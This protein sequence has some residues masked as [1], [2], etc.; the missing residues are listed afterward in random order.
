MIEPGGGRFSYTYDANGRITR[1]INPQSLP[2]TWAYDN[3]GKVLAKYLANG[4]RAS[5]TWDAADRLTHLANMPPIGTSTSTF[6][7]AYD[8]ADNRTRVAE[9][10][11]NRVTWTYDASYQ[12]L[13]ER[14][15]GGSGYAITYSYDA[16]GNRLTM[17]QSGV[18]TTFTYDPANQLKTFKDNTGT[19]TLSWDNN[20]NQAGQIA[21]SGGR[22]TFTWDFENRSTQALLPLGLPNTMTYDADGRRVKKVD[23]S[24]TAKAVWD[25][26]NIL[27]ETDQSNVTQ[28]EYSLQP[29]DYGNLV[30]QYRSG[31]TQFFLFDALGSSDRLV[32]SAANVT[33][34]F[35]YRAFGQLQ[36]RTGPTVTPF[37]FVGQHQYYF[38]SDLGRHFIRARFYDPAVGRWLSKDPLGPVEDHNLYRYVNNRPA[39]AIDPSGLGKCPLTNAD[40]ARLDQLISDLGSPIFR[41][42]Q[43]AFA[44][45][46]IF[47]N[48]HLA[49]LGQI[50]LILENSS[51][52]TGDAEIRRLITRLLD[53]VRGRV[54]TYVDQ[55]VGPKPAEIV[56]GVGGLLVLLCQPSLGKRIRKQLDSERNHIER[57]ID[58]LDNRLSRRLWRDRAQMVRWLDQ[59][60]ALNARL[61]AIEDLLSLSFLVCP[62]I[63]FILG[64]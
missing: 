15:S 62:C 32:D 8:K 35:V 6:D 44:A 41:K 48:D 59:L 24:G 34:T 28:A 42:R 33:D 4:F 50:I 53:V 21:P 55:M 36:K 14:R 27:L 46:V 45:L 11:A 19:T 7:Y 29:A 16:A 26:Q 2:V 63:Q 37:T 10:S 17:L 25:D 1:L 58:V 40:K 64:K 52:N 51:S 23:A 39:S 47:M 61:K 18:R 12:L 9:A 54:T 13:S 31:G 60:A 49:C 30:S 38:D 57:M 43:A 5:Q 3:A 56:Q 20:G 22:T